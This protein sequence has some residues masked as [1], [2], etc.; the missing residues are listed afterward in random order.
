MCSS[1]LTGAAGIQ[2]NPG[3]P[4]QPG[5]KGD[6]GE[7]GINWRGTWAP[8]TAYVPR[9]CVAHNGSSYI[10]TAANTNS[11]PATSSSWNL[12]AAQG[13][14]GAIGQ[15]GSSGIK[16]DVGDRGL[17]GVQGAIGL[18]GIP[19]APG[20]GLIPSA[21]VNLPLATGLTGYLQIRRIGTFAHLQGIVGASIPG[22]AI[23]A[24]NLPGAFRP[25]IDKLLPVPQMPTTG[26]SNFSVGICRVTVSD[27]IILSSDERV[28]NTT[29]NYTID[30][31]FAY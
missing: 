16:G 4:G 29:C 23:V 10:A 1:D 18:Q 3:A 24:A 26:G 19:G 6:R 20:A 13:A 22:V 21:W 2:G 31:V 30:S 9:D 28:K 15:T 25:S 14:T 27:Q 12:L 8:T 5:T 11:I 17:Q 7:V